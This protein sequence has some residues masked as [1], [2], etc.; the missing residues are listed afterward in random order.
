MWSSD[1]RTA[2]YTNPYTKLR[3][4]ESE[5]SVNWSFPP[6]RQPLSAASNEPLLGL[7]P[8]NEELMTNEKLTIAKHRRAAEA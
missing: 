2:N 6:S 4:N 3:V 1:E 8:T 7:I 5:R